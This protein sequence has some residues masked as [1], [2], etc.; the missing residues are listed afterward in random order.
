MSRKR[1]FTLVELLVVIAIIGILVALLLPAIQYARESAR[2]TQCSSN[3]RNV[4]VAL[5]NFHDSYGSFPAGWNADVPDGEP[6]WGWGAYLLGHLEQN[7]LLDSQIH[8]DAHID[9]PENE[10][11]RATVIPIYLC[12]S[13]PGEKKFMLTGLHN[14]LFEI[15]KSNYVGVFGSEEIEV[16]PSN[17]DGVFFHNSRIRLAD[18]ILDGTSNTLAIGERSSKLGSS[19]WVGMVHGATDAM[20]RVVGS[21]D[22]TPNDPHAHFDDFSSYHATGAHFALADGSVRLINSDIDWAVYQG[23][24]TRRGGEAVSAP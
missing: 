12:P 22:H 1:G 10:I 15:A 6:G 24:C 8:L 11:A 16:D 23:L 17:G 5:Q 4:G 20:A 18:I 13:D 19:T 21:A 7:S 14:P 2:R 9:E 3:L